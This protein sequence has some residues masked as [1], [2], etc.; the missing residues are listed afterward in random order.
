MTADIATRPRGV[1]APV[2]AILVA[3]MRS[4]LAYRSDVVV[5]IIGL[6]SRLFLLKVLWDA[7]Y[8][9]HGSVSG[10]TQ[11]TA[12]SYALLAALLS[13]LFQPWQFFPLVE[14]VRTGDI[15]FDV[16]RPIG[17]VTMTSA[18]QTGAILASAPRILF[19]AILAVVL[20]GGVPAPEPAVAAA[21]CVSLILGA[22]NSVICNVIVNMAAFWSLEIGGAL[23]VYQVAVS[24]CSGALVPFWFM[25]GWLATL[26][27]FLPFSAQVSTPATIA[28][29][30]GID[31]R[32]V[33]LL[34]VQ[35]I[36]IVLLIL[37]AR[38]VAAR[39]VRRLVVQGG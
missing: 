22:A 13:S 26:L 2:R 15:V 31:L 3:T 32:T 18:E 12:V 33:F 16:L 29:G 8:Q 7:I 5:G 9:G 19:G 37:A 20:L 38:I 23:V 25:P 30:S 10:V 14:K 17:L 34:L 11:Q 27:S 21:F 28:L 6:L 35:A 36:W 24:F 39:G 1:R 4:V